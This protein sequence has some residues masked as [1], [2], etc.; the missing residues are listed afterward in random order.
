MW[1]TSALT[2]LLESNIILR[3]KKLRVP[4]WIGRSY[5]VH[6]MKS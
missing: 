5:N 1:L 4:V 3:A 6:G 2:L